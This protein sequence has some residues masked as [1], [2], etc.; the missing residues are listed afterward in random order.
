[1]H[2]QTV[3]LVLVPSLI[4]SSEVLHSEW[5]RQLVARDQSLVNC[6]RGHSMQS[7]VTL[8]LAGTSLVPGGHDGKV[9]S[10]GVA[11]GSDESDVTPP[12]RQSPTKDRATKDIILKEDPNARIAVMGDLNSFF[13]SKP[14]QTLRDAG[15]K[16]VLDFLPADQRYTY[17]FQGDSQVLDHILVTPNLYDMLQ[18]VII[19]HVNADFPPPVPDDP[20]PIRKSDHDPIIAIFGAK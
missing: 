18:D 20:S 11:G 3:S 4:L 8:P 6:P 1:L 16:H 10:S 14:V 5:C 15:L 9:T 13:D 2:V 12:H 17:I 19:L 7:S